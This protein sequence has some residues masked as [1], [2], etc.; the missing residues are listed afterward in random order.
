MKEIRTTEW[1]IFFIELVGILCIFF[2]YGTGTFAWTEETCKDPQNKIAEGVYARGDPNISLQYTHGDNSSG[3]FSTGC[4]T[5]NYDIQ[6]TKYAEGQSDVFT[7]VGGAQKGEDT[8][9]STF[10]VSSASDKIAGKIFS[11]KIKGSGAQETHKEIFASSEE[12]KESAM[13]GNTTGADF[14]DSAS[15]QNYSNEKPL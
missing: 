2:V 10:S 13:A 15:G 12:M 11:L 4:A 1:R 3:G 14:R 8:P 5:G 7:Y 9:W 6:D